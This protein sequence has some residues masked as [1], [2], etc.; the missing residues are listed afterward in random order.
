MGDL[1]RLNIN[2]GRTPVRDKCSGRASDG[3]LPT[4]AHATT[5]I[6]LTRS[7]CMRLAHE[8]AQLPFEGRVAKARTRREPE[9]IVIVKAFLAGQEKV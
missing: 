5:I 2:P 6:I 4:L 8:L 1:G 7:F 3:P 9:R